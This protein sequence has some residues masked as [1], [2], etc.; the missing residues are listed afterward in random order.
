MSITEVFREAFYEAAQQ[1]WPGL[2]PAQFG[3]A[4]RAW[5]SRQESS[6]LTLM[7]VAIGVEGE[8]RDRYGPPE[9]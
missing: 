8:L 5:L 1:C 9:R 3:D 2:T 7:Q 6:S 4:S